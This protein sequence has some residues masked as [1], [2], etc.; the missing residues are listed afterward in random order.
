[1]E[2]RILNQI[3]D[4][5]KKS[6]QAELKIPRRSKSYDGSVNKRG[7]SAPISSGNLYKSVNVFWENDFDDPFPTLII[8]FGN[9]DYW[10]WVNYGRRPGRYPPLKAIDKWVTQKKGFAQIIR[11]PGGRFTKRKSLV[12]LIRRSIATLGYRGTFFI[13]N[14]LEKSKNKV[15]EEIGEAAALY[16]DKIISQGLVFTQSEN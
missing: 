7:T 8:D 10:Y 11:G 6:I 2:E 14:A 16:I 3:A 13:E 15:L 4:T 9:A 12:F 1:M 5:V